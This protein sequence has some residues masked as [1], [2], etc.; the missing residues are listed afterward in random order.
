MTKSQKELGRA[1]QSQSLINQNSVVFFIETII[2]DFVIWAESSMDD[3]EN[4]NLH[5]SWLKDFFNNYSYL[6]KN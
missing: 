6:Q 5:L 3:S 1:E 2:C 4:K